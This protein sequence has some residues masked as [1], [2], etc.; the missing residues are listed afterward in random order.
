M[1]DERLAM[2]LAAAAAGSAGVLVAY[3][4]G[5]RSTDWWAGFQAGLA[6]SDGLGPHVFG[7]LGAFGLVGLSVA[8]AL[9]AERKNPPR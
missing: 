4:A 5:Q 3:W 6:G 8:L 1:A 9:A 2:R 7:I